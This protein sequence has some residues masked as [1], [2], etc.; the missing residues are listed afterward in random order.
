MICVISLIVFGI[1]GIFSASHRETAREAWDCIKSSAKN[2]PCDT[3]LDDRMRA[4]A[5]GKALDV[6]PSLGRFLNRYFGPLSWIFLILLLLSGFLAF[7]GA[8]N[9]AVHGNCYGPDAEQPCTLDSLTDGA[10]TKPINGTDTASTPE[11]GESGEETG[12]LGG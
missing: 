2:E 3:G 11:G 12:L 10:D 1:L 5:V 9:L 7:Q 6:H 8:Y 4:S